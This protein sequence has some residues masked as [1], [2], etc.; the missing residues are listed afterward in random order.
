MKRVLVTGATGFIGRQSLVHLQRAGFEVHAVSSTHRPAE[1]GAEWHAANLLDESP[2][3]LFKRVKPSHLMHFAW[4]AEPGR[5][6]TAPQ[7]YSWVSASMRLLAAFA[8]NGGRRAVLAGTCA[9]YDWRYGWCNE[10]LTPLASSSPYSACKNALRLLAES[11]L[12]QQGMSV[13][14][15]RIFHLYGPHERPERLVSSVIASLLRGQPALCTAGQ[16]LRDFMHVADVAAAFVALL[17]AEE[18]SGAV[19]I[20]SGKP[21]AVSDVLQRLATR[22]GRM[23]LLQLGARATPASEP[24]L[25]VGDNRRLSDEVRW[26]PSYDLDRGLAAT[27]AWWRE[28]AL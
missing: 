8:A 27:A 26:A 4:Y 19:N 2:D 25:L 12:A 10:V 11:F 20:S 14:W 22:L 7:N 28:Q 17:Q 24:P 15:G 13:A 16:Q 1:Q 6:W 21:A 18:V 9:E 5:Y 23:D 3:E